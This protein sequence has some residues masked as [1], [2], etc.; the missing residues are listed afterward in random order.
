[1]VWLL[2]QAQCVVGRNTTAS[3][4]QQARALQQSETCA[5]PIGFTEHVLSTGIAGED[6]VSVYAADLDGD[7]YVD[8][9]I[10]SYWSDKVAWYE[11]AGS[12]F[13]QREITTPTT[14]QLGVWSVYATDLDADGDVDVLVGGAVSMLVWY[15]S[16]GGSP[17]SFQERIISTT[18][19]QVRTVYAA[20][21]DGNGAIDVLAASFDDDTLAW[22]ESDGGL[23]PSFT[24][25]VISTTVDGAYAVSAADLDGDAHIDVLAGG[26]NDGFAWYRN[27]GASPPTF[28][29]RVLPSTGLAVPGV[30]SMS[31][32]DL[33]G[34]QDLDLLVTYNNMIAWYENNGANPPAFSANIITSQAL[35]ALQAYAA[36]VNNDGYLDVVAVSNSDNTVAWYENDGNNQ[37]PQFAIRTVS[38]TADGPHG[39]IPIDMDND[40]AV[41]ILYGSYPYEGATSIGTLAWF[42]NSCVIPTV[43]PTAEPT[44]KPTAQPTVEPTMA[45]SSEDLTGSKKSKKKHI[46]KQWWLYFILALIAPLV[47][48]IIGLIMKYR[49]YFGKSAPEDAAKP[50]VE[51]SINIG[52][53]KKPVQDSKEDPR[54]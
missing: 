34:D 54:E 52:E 5:E 48:T 2:A 18:A 20:D 36:D 12:T 4:A 13:V 3:L 53:T 23:P 7:G 1:M 44:A 17:P 8:P 15:E 32:A 31:V 33:D 27:N 9:I 6:F 40:G 47:L 41:D 45:P 43:P 42:E 37:H 49:K 39:M 35:F 51:F 11:R 16:D 46:L 29:H 19:G 10:V 50:A 26:F 21:V 30:R 28:Q 22:Y 24:K 25:R 38:T 14:P